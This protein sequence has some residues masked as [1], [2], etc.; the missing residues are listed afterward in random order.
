MEISIQGEDQMP[1]VV[2]QLAVQFPEERQFFLKG[3]LGSGK[4]SLVR[5]FAHFLGS[6]DQVTS[7][8]FSLIQEYE[9]PRG[10]I[11]HMDLYRL[12]DASE[13]EDLGLEEYLESGNWCFIEWPEILP[14]W[15]KEEG[16]TINIFIESRD[17]R[18][19]V[20]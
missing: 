10:I 4:T 3:D 5:Q 20:I 14:G 15:M 2:R 7:P 9:S 18:K 19:I 13:L 1:E 16:L 11:Y 8:T 17:E 12:E 6:K